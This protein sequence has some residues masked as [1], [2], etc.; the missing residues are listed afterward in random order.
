M[1]RNQKQE[2][3][4]R[5]RFVVVSTFEIW[6]YSI[7]CC[8]ILRLIYDSFL[9]LLPPSFLFLGYWLIVAL[10]DTK[11][12]MK[13]LSKSL[14]YKDAMRMVNGACVLCCRSMELFTS[15]SNR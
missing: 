8:R 5:V 15:P 11:V 13:K 10:H 3:M 4:T 12:D 9:L 14:G 7:H 2:I 1:E 6:L